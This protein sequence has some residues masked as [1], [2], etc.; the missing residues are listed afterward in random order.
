MPDRGVFCRHA[1]ARLHALLAGC[2]LAMAALLGACGGGSSEGVKIS[3]N[4]LVVYSSLPFEG[5]SRAQAI[6]VLAAERLALDQAGNRVGDR[7][8]KL[9][10]LDDA[11]AN[12]NKWDPGQIAANAHKAAQDP[13]TIAYL[14]ELDPGAS[15]VS[16]PVLNQAD[17]LAV[18]P[19]DTDTG[20]TRSNGGGKDDPEKFYPTGKRNFARVIQS[21]RVQAKAL[22]S[23]MKVLGATKVYLLHDQQDY[24]TG[25]AAQVADAAKDQGIAVVADEPVRIGGGDY[26]DL[27]GKV[28]GSGADAVFFGGPGEAGEAQLF[29]DLHA[30]NPALALFGSRIMAQPAFVSKLGPAASRTFIT[31]P[32]LDP[33]LYPPSAQQFFKDFEAKY[34]RAPQPMAI[35]GYEAMSALLAALKDAG[36]NS[37][38]RQAVIDAFFG[39]NN[40]QSVLGTYS[41]DDNGDT[42]LSDYGG[43]KIVA[44][45]LLFDRQLGKP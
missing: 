23:Y 39:L 31:Q 27:A 8:V 41:I 26:R 6:D 20:L 1:P 4:T 35:Y 43:Y 36:D 18:S 16:I 14:G 11:S 17:I 2:L 10:S 38:D 5:P 30:A 19:G 28:K 9:V 25:L 37:N 12:D 24:G 33:K 3:G 44:G 40:R 22:A 29:K 42:T 7:N 13:K 15:G 32:V 34:G 21:D 45:R